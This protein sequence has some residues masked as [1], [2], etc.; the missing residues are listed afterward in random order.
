MV[1]RYWVGG[2]A[3][4]LLGE[5]LRSLKPEW[6]VG[7]GSHRVGGWARQLRGARG[8]IL[9]P[10]YACLHLFCVTLLLLAVL[11]TLVLTLQTQL[12]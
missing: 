1:G 6:V 3:G 9:C 5:R 11:G 8:G 12:L 10:L 4:Q 7:Q 2:W